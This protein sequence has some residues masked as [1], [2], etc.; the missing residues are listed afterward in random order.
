MNQWMEVHMM[1]I[2]DFFGVPQPPQHPQRGWMI[3]NQ[4]IAFEEDPTIN[5]VQQNQRNIPQTNMV[6]K[7]VGVEP[8]RVESPR[9]EPPI[10]RERQ[11]RVVMV[12][13]NQYADEVIHQIRRDDI[14]AN[15]NR[16]AMVERIMA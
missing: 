7:G 6:N 9:P 11:P 10:P 4:G 3:E 13:R 1:R 12:N 8:P 2:T 16:V 5:Q 14:V 15:N